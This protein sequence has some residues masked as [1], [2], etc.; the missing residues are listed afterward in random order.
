[1]CGCCA[2]S[3]A[4]RWTESGYLS[5]A[6]VA[7]LGDV[8]GPGEPRAE[9]LHPSRPGPDPAVG[10]ALRHRR[11]RRTH[12]ARRPTR[13]CA[14]GW[15]PRPR[16]AWSRISPLADAL[17]RQAAHLDLTDAN[18]VV[19]RAA[20]GPRP[21]RGHRLR[22]PV[23]HLGGV[24]TRDHGVVGAGSRWHRTDIDPAGV[25]AFHAVRPLTAAEADAVWPLLVLR[26]AVLI[27]SGAQ[28]AA[29]DPDNAYITEQ[30]DAEWRMFEQA[31]SVPIDVM[32]AVIKRRSGARR[33]RRPGRA[34]GPARRR[35]DPAV[36]GHAGPVDHL[37][38]LR[39]RVRRRRWLMSRTSRTN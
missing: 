30:S 35:S 13:R 27:V 18:V 26:T 24:R 19:S 7:G 12:F 39:R 2:T 25:R 29:L 6:A 21:G 17:P 34:A 1:M 11:C 3:R 14:T 37:R 9:G 23:R 16:E 5:P 36:G 8:A 20:G 33:C 38:R 28:Q 22:R 10:S 15:T 31:T 4:A 32:T